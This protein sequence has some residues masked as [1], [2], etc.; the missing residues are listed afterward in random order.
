MTHFNGL[1]PAQAERLAMLAEEAAEVIQVIGKILRHGYDSSHPD[2]PHITNRELL[3]RE[4]TDF[5]AVEN[6]IHALDRVFMPSSMGL[7]I[8]WRKK[9]R[10]AH[11][12]EEPKP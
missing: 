3:Q 7:D 10:Y 4:L 2:R 1:T 9:L 5:A 6:Q 8:A 11:H 12:Q